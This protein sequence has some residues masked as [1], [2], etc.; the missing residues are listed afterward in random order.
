MLIAAAISVATLGYP[1]LALLVGAESLGV[2][3]PGETALIAAGVLARSGHLK[4]ELVI[5]VAAAAAIVGDNIGYVLGRKYGRRLFEL[6]GPFLDR[7]RELMKR[8]ER[9]FARH[10]PKAVFLGRWVTG[11][12]TVAAWLAGAEKMPWD[13]FFRWNALGGVAW[14]TSIGLLAYALGS[15]VGSLVTLLGLAGLALVVVVA[16]PY[17]AHRSARD[18]H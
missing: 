2:P 6:N 1:A 4:I 3:V 12:R 7:R 9:F 17:L 14:A 11:V 5:P 16:I 10:G 15:S 13:S 18:D 8:G